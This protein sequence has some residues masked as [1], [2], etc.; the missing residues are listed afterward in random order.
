LHK[1]D[2][3]DEVSNF[4]NLVDLTQKFGGDA[5]FLIRFFDRPN[6]PQQAMESSNT[7]DL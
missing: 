3:I 2:E 1:T 7:K 5:L 4:H 6:P